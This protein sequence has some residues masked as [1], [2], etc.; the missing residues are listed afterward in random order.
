MD[1]NQAIETIIGLDKEIEA[2]K[3]LTLQIERY[4][5]KVEGENSTMS[6]C[7]RTIKKLNKGKNKSIDAL[8]E[9]ED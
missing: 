8:C 4:V 2:I 1:F 9:W 6:A 5:E 3:I 7:L